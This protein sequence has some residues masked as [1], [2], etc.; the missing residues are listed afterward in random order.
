MRQPAPPQRARCAL[1]DGP[2]VLAPALVDREQTAAI[3][4]LQL[5]AT[6]ARRAWWNLTVRSTVLAAF[7]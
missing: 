4:E 3:A 6:P 2:Q 1:I 5:T 7:D